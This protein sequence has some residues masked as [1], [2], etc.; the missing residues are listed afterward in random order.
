M[1]PR[2]LAALLLGA[3]LVAPAVVGLVTASPVPLSVCSPCDRG[4]E[5]A[6]HGHDLE[7]QIQRSTATV[8]VHPNGS[9]TWTVRNRLSGADVDDLR[10]S[11]ALLEQVASESL[12][13]RSTAGYEPM[14]VDA[15]M[16]ANDTVVLRYRTPDFADRQLGVLRS[17]YFR[18]QSGAYLRSGLGADRLRVLAPEGMTV[19][20]GVPGASV[21]GRE[22]TLRSFESADDG[23]FVVFAP[24]GSAL[25]GLQATLVIGLAFAPIVAKNLLWLVCIPVGLLVAATAVASRGV[26][27]VVPAASTARAR[28]A[29]VIVAG[30][31]LLT[32]A[33]SFMAPTT[34]GGVWTRSILLAGGIA[35]GVAGGVAA[36]WPDRLAIREQ[37]F[38]I[39]G[40]LA[41]GWT[42]A[43]VALGPTWA[44]RQSVLFGVALPLLTLLG[45][46]LGYVSV[47]QRRREW[48]LALSVI[49]GLYAIFLVL[50]QPIAEMGGSLYF[51]LPF[52][53]SGLALLAAVLSV[54]LL[55]LGAVLPGRGDDP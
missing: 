23:P 13:Y 22:M 53:F 27:T 10:Q 26:A 20:T 46:P 49:A 39:V 44:R 36:R 3:A 40:G 15:G 19:A 30:L 12:Q 51:L 32:A 11:D 5:S 25:G 29:G 33:L 21:D 4:F 17:D 37:G 1:R 35:A 54:P 24:E 41:L 31:G 52:L 47:Q 45:L 18:D 9:A 43:I 14:L 28:R 38:V 2:R 7:V 55:A 42:T 6:A 16:A 34:L 50:T 48:F 8:H